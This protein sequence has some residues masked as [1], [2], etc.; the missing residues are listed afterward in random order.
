[1][2][3]FSKL[4]YD[5][6]IS[7]YSRKYDAIMTLVKLQFLYFNN[8]ILISQVFIF[9]SYFDL[10]FFLHSLGRDDTKPGTSAAGHGQKDQC[11]IITPSLFYCEM[12]K[13]KDTNRK[14]NIKTKDIFKF[15]N[16][17]SKK[18]N[19]YILVI[20]LMN[21]IQEISVGYFL[22]SFFYK[23]RLLIKFWSL[24]NQ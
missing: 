16:L 18:F 3:T 23:D 10:Y 6:I 4:V 20:L 8:F 13:L 24:Y 1:M 17:E 22:Y 7:K 15:E 12:K 9:L 2:K 21:D 14:K 5:E 19:R 11:K